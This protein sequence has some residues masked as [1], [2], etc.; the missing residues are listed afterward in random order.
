MWSVHGALTGEKNF[1]RQRI[2]G[3]FISKKRSGRYLK[4]GNSI[5]H[6]GDCEEF[7]VIEY[8]VY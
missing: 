4:E 8:Q 3:F 6:L 1:S 7:D 5:L 2:E